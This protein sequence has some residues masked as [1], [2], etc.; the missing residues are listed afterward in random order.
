MKKF[1]MFLAIIGMSIVLTP[2]IAEAG[3]DDCVPDILYCCDGTQHNIVVCG[4]GWERVVD[5]WIWE[6][7]LCDPCN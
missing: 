6:D 7:L 3:P 1:F 5:Y 2:D 4:T